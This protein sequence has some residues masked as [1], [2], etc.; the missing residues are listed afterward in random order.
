MATIV[1]PN[2]NNQQ[3]AS[4]MTLLADLSFDVDFDVYAENSMVIVGFD[5]EQPDTY[6]EGLVERLDTFVGNESNDHNVYHS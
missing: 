1:I 3:A 2:L 4:I 6:L 5:K